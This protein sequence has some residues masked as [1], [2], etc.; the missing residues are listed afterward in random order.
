MLCLPERGC[1]A[2]IIVATHQRIGDVRQSLDTILHHMRQLVRE[3]QQ[4]VDAVAGMS[5]KVF[6][7]EANGMAPYKRLDLLERAASAN[8][9]CQHK[10][11]TKRR[12]QATH[13]E[14]MATEPHPSRCAP[15]ATAPRRQTRGWHCRARRLSTVAHES[16][17]ESALRTALQHR[18][19]PEARRAHE[20]IATNQRLRT[21]EL[22]SHGQLNDTLEPE[23]QLIHKT[24]TTSMLFFLSNKH[25]SP[26]QINNW[27]V[28][29]QS[30]NITDENQQRPHK[31]QPNKR[32]RRSCT[33]A[34]G[35]DQ[36]TIPCMAHTVHVAFPAK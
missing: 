2:E 9:Q 29:Y 15:A 25:I 5:D 30:N 27:F 32:K 8:N 19:D 23:T 21:C 10:H 24:P 20:R 3:C 22:Q 26:D 1:P 6:V 12:P 34:F 31:Y 28:V 13:S 7:V 33:L 14:R 4:R 16:V 17:G 11:R 35:F 18:P 36:N